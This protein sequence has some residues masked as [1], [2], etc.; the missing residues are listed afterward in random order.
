[1]PRTTSRQP[2]T[3]AP[4]LAPRASR[5]GISLLEVLI[6]MFVLLFGLM[7]VAAIFPVGNHYA[8]RGDQFER[9]AALADAAFAQLK[10]RGM[11]RP[12]RWLYGGNPS[13]PGTL[14]AP[15]AFINA[16]GGAQIPLTA[17]ANDPHPGH[18]FVIDPLG[19]GDVWG[20]T[21][22]DAFPLKQ[23]DP[24][25]NDPKLLAVNSSMP[26]NWKRS[27]QNLGQTAGVNWPIRRVTLAMP[28]PNLSAGQPALI[29]MPPLAARLNFSLPDDLA[30]ELP[31][32]TDRP[33]VQPWE[34][35]TQGDENPANDVP[36]T[37]ANKGDYT[38]LATVV[39]TTGDSNFDHIS[40]GVAALQPTH[41]MFGSELY[42]VSVA[43]FYKR[44][45]GQPGAGERS[46][47]AQMLPGGE[48]VL[49][50][51]TASDAA[52]N[53]EF[54]DAALDGVRSG[55]WIAIAGVHPT[56]GR[57]LL[58]WYRLL[59]L[60]EATQ[61]NSSGGVQ[62]T[63]LANIAAFRNATLDGPDWPVDPAY[64]SSG[65]PI[66]DLRA[67]LLPGVIGVST[68]YVPMER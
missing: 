20:Q 46:L 33:G 53:A 41:P 11:L 62:I 32:Q 18:A 65:T 61:E 1:M 4:R 16:F 24:A 57:L 66:Q 3:R 19:T 27:M 17:G 52:T 44:D 67:I 14:A 54:V 28:N 15:Y 21:D 7:G 58:K 29:G 31:R 34:A 37:R 38:W 51:D 13:Q 26:L 40:D 8:G 10:A 64:A 35:N 68:H 56:S 60:D 55:N 23:M 22:A 2:R 12:E 50:N 25:G 6:S 63:T 49:Y 45:L 30:V 42:E 59:S 43:V 39:P 48:L 47:A 5:R 36:L 9:G